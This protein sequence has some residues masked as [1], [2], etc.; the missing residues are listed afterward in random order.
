MELQKV[1]A[2]LER[3]GIGV[4]GVSYD[5]PAVLHEFA[6]AKG[7]AFPLLSD[8]G[9]RVITELGLLDRDLAAH[10][11]AFGVPTQ[12]HQLGVA[13]PAVFVLDE[14]GR[15]VEKRIKENY[16][17]RESGLKLAAEGLGL[18]LAGPAGTGR[19]ASA[20]GSHV[21]VTAVTDG[22]EYVRWQEAR[23]RVVIEVEPGWHVYGRPIPEGY[24]PLEVSVEAAPE[25][26]V[27]QPAYPPARPFRVEGLDE[28]FHVL[29]GRFEVAIPYAVDVPPDHGPIDLKLTVRY[30]CCSATECLPPAAVSVELRQEQ[31]APS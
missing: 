24:V 28:N 12:E 8:A 5:P 31:A 11:A 18:D 16:R 21:T 27:G 20:T 4:V 19:E 25:V 22:V 26:R 2:G 13:Y 10:H 3:A 9:S 30:Q 23:L 29:E 17:V 7:I 15:V 6:S 1:Q 14:A